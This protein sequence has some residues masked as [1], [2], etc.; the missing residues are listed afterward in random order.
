MGLCM[1]LDDPMNFGPEFKDCQVFCWCCMGTPRDV[2]GRV[3]QV[4]ELPHSW[5]LY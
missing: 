4:Y 2:S 1:I 5:F 3:R